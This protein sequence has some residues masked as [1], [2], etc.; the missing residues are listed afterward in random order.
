MK[1]SQHIFVGRRDIC[2]NTNSASGE[3]PR[4]LLISLARSQSKDLTKMRPLVADLVC[5]FTDYEEKV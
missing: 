1:Y 3:L 2:I 5:T 4:S